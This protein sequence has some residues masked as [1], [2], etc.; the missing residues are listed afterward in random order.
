MTP[1]L[2]PYGWPCPT[3]DHVAARCGTKL[4]PHKSASMNPT[5]LPRGAA[6]FELSA[7]PCFAMLLIQTCLHVSRLVVQLQGFLEGLR[8]RFWYH[9]MVSNGP[10]LPVDFHSLFYSSVELVGWLLCLL[11]FVCVLFLMGAFMPLSSTYLHLAL[12]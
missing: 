3:I 10:E 4:H 6:W 9:L 1:F 5:H 12:A 8:T 11:V 2:T 7:P